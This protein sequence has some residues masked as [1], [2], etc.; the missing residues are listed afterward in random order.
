MKSFCLLAAIGLALT[1]GLAS[2]CS[3]GAVSAAPTENQSDEIQ[4]SDDVIKLL[5]ENNT[6]TAAVKAHQRETGLS[7]A[8]AKKQVEVVMK[9]DGIKIGENR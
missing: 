3:R 7:L 8:E 2:G 1:I 5:R 9:R 6:M 4:L